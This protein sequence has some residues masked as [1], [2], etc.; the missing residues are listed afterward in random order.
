MNKTASP[1]V[2][3]YDGV[4]AEWFDTDAVKNYV[5]QWLPWLNIVIRDDLVG[6]ASAPLD[7]LAELFSRLRVRH[8]SKRVVVN[9]ILKPELDY[10]TRLLTGRSR[11]T[12]GVVY[13]GVELQRA[14]YGMMSAEE[15]RLDGV[16][17]WITERAIVTWD[18]NDR[19]FH[20]RVSV[21]GYPSIIST[22]GMVI[23]PAR[24]RAYY[25]SRRFGIGTEPKT[26]PADGRY[27]EFRTQAVTE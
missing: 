9:R 18:E 17:V 23:A 22:T 13:D 10:E 14:V 24:E 19:R 26:S 12:A 7:T 15:R 6:Y 16:S 20:A 1:T 3:I 4:D 8:P 25:I 2:Y 27:L 11:A 5:E 21:Y